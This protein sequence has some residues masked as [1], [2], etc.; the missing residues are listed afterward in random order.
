MMREVLSPTPAGKKVLH[1]HF[2][3]G[4]DLLLDILEE[5]LA[6]EVPPHKRHQIAFSVFGQCLYYHGAGRIIPL[7]VEES[8]LRAHYGVDELSA[9]IT[10]VCLAA[11]G[12]GP[13]VVRPA[14]PAT[15]RKAALPRRASR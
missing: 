14:R 4:F 5:I 8:E 9:H 10:Q 11:L 12:L 7:V 13:P 15:V 1:E 6:P 2:R 3:R